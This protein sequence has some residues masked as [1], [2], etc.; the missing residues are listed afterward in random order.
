MI[1]S[2]TNS[3]ADTS[4]AKLFM[5]GISHYLASHIHLLK[6]PTKL[7]ISCYGKK[8]KLETKIVYS[9]W[10]H[11]QLEVNNALQT[12]MWFANAPSRD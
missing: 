5:Y 10:P 6:T 9:Q 4:V 12:L 3:K 8:K 7:V 1:G 2:S 11:F